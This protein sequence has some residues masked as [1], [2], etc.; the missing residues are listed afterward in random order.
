MSFIGLELAETAVP[1]VV[2][3][4]EETGGEEDEEEI[5]PGQPQVKIKRDKCEMVN[6]DE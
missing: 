4:G 2:V 6:G 3:E 1:P 5:R